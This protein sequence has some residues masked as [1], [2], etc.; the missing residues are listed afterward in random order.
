LPDVAIE[1]KR[2]QSIAATLLL[3]IVAWGI[4]TI[5]IAGI[6]EHKD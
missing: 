4:L 6:K 1:P 2:L 3:G 5:F